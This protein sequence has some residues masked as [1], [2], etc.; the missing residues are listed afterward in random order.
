MMRIGRGLR[1]LLPLGL[2][3]CG[4]L[5]LLFFGLCLRTDLGGWN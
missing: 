5:L 4:E 1:L 3:L 2:L